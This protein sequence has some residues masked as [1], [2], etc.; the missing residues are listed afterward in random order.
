MS[1]EQDKLKHSKRIHQDEVH[2]AKNVSV[3]K[4]YG[5]PVK[6]GEE[7]RLHKV[8]GITCGNPKCVMCMNPRKSFN[9]LTM[10]EKKFIQREKW[11][12]NT[13]PNM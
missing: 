10:Q 8:N 9:E 6:N 7:H 12:D 13:E 3:A 4:A 1:T 2:I 11:N 5:I